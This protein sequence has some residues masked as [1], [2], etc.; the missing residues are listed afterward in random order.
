M[1]LFVRKIL[2]PNKIYH[3]DNLQVLKDNI[4]DESIDLIYLDPPFN[5][6]R[7][8]S[9]LLSE[10]VIEGL[11]VNDLIFDDRW[12]WCRKRCS[13]Y[14]YIINNST[15]DMK[16]LFEFFYGYFGRSNIMAYLTMIGCRLIELF[17]V[18]SPT[19]SLYL[20]CDPNISH[21]LKI[22]LDN[23]FGVDNFRNEIS[24]CYKTWPIKA[25]QFSRSHDTI[26]FYSKSKTNKFNIQYID[27]SYETRKRT[28]GKKQQSIMKNG[29]LSKILID[30]EARTPCRD[31]WDLSVLH[32]SAKERLGYPTQKPEALLER[33][34]R[35]S[36]SEG[37]TVLDPCFG[38]GTA[39]AVSERLG[40]RWIGIDQSEIAVN[41]TIE[42]LNENFGKLF[43]K[44]DV[45]DS[46]S[47]A[48]RSEVET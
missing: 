1:L 34:I 4:P 20:H 30:E 42:R 10:S 45:I 38:S 43:L 8:Y 24:W 23:I 3:G 17:R 44:Y 48:I 35:S 46:S 12:M 33:I 31:W 16:R 6:N 15:I 19:G 9:G 41:V 40:R 14:E 2:L 11:T 25:H 28:K 5:S 39:L 27:I 36:S 13:E 47:L 18:L 32:P 22:L 7:S 29:K 26:L 37:D 21:Y